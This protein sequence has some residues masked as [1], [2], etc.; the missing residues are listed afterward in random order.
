MVRVHGTGT[1]GTCNGVGTFPFDVVNDDVV[2][3]CSNELQT[4]YWRLNAMNSQTFWT[5]TK[6]LPAKKAVSS[7]R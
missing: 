6:R 5:A 1:W 3:D 4:N 7:L 2:I